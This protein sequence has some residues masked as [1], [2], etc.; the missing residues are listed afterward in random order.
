[1][2]INKE[3]IKSIIEYVLIFLIFFVGIRK[4]GYYKEDSLI[5]VYIIQLVALLHCLF[6]D[7]IKINYVVGI[8]LI[9]FCIS[10]F[11]PV[12]IGNVATISGALNIGIRIYSMFLIYLVVTNSKNKEKYIKS[13]VGITL[14]F[15]ILALDE[16]SFRIFERP[17]NF[18]GGGY[19]SE[20]TSRVSGVLQYSNILGILCLISIIYLYSLLKKVNK[21]ITNVV[22]LKILITF[23]TIIVLLTESKMV[24]LLYLVVGIISSF[25]EKKVENIFYIILNLL[26][27]V[28]IV[29]LIRQI[30]I[31]VIIP[32]II[33]MMVY[34]ILEEILKNKK[35]KYLLLYNAICISI[36]IAIFII[37]F[38]YIENIGII[39][40]IEDYLHNFNSTKLRF[41]YYQ[42]ALKLIVDSPLNFIFGLGGN[43]FR[44]MYETVQSIE[45]ISLETHSFFVQVFLESGVIGLISIIIP[46][47][48]LLKN[49]KNF[50]ARKILFVL[51]IFATFDVFLTYTFMLFILA[52]IMAFCDVKQ[53]EVNL[54]FKAIN[55]IIYTSIFVLQT[56]QVIAFFIEPIE[57]NN[58]NK[59]LNEQEK[60]INRCEIAL[61]LDPF[62]IEYIRNCNVAYTTY[63]EMLEIKKE[64]YGSDYTI[65]SYDIVNKIY[66][67][68]E[69]ENIYEKSNKYA[70]E[71]NIYYINKYVNE[72]VFSNYSNDIEKGYEYYLGKLINNLDRLRLEH[73]KNNYAIDIYNELSNDVYSNYSSINL[74]INSQEISNRINTLKENII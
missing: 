20:E 2:Q 33:A 65:S 7:K 21:S 35:R 26:I 1:M 16:M 45:Y 27:S 71:D 53:K 28:V 6:N 12:I 3:K 41:I 14:V 66:K 56:L 31:F 48:Y 23:F 13:I 4:G 55:I 36:I 9:F 22:I 24:L 67:N 15:G 42:D 60:I 8:C 54:K 43:A 46:I 52:I 10:Y 63:L 39:S 11:L 69:I 51:I 59:T 18:L 68:I 40:S 50:L 58:L 73:N 32:S 29:S 19:I 34:F 49:S 5:F 61:K 74:T 25:I 37:G 57:V 44:T 47:K 72:L 17:L 30:S 70:L 62:D 38:N 64:L